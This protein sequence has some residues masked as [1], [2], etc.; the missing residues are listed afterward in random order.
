MC[1]IEERIEV[2]VSECRRRVG[3]PSDEYRRL[4]FT[5]WQD[6]LVVL[7][8]SLR[9]SFLRSFRSSC[10]VFDLRSCEGEIRCSGCKGRLV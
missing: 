10:D 8:E 6:E 3:L 9:G 2:V 5:V 7:V 1:F 4:L